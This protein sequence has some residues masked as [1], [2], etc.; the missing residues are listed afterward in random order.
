MSFDLFKGSGLWEV[1]L[2]NGELEF[3]YRIIPL[4]SIKK[5]VSF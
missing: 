1:E 5:Y 3:F 4:T 2:D